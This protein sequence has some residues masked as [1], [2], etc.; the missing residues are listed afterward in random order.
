MPR[1]GTIRNMG[2]VAR[3]MADARRERAR[4]KKE[5]E[6][7]EPTKPTSDRSDDLAATLK[8]LAEALGDEAQAAEDHGG[9]ATKWNGLFQMAKRAL[10]MTTGKEAFAGTPDQQPAANHA[11]YVE[12]A[13]AAERAEAWPQA[14]ALWLRAS[15]T[16]GDVDRALGYVRSA[17]A[18]KHRHAI[19][20]KLEKIAK[21]VLKVPTLKYRQSDAL[22][23]HELSVGQIKLALRAAY[24]AGRQS[25]R[26][27]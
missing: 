15:E 1:R 23:F 16:C 22:D 11:D 3:E 26:A 4:Q 18:C 13:E 2:R 10:E 25:E 19:D 9:D 27:K 21:N 6:S 8:G 14:A 5:E 7:S 17:E 12:E 20:S 24:E